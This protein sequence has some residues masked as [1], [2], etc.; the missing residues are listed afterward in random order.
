MGASLL[1]FD[2]LGHRYWLQGREVRSV[3]TILRM[4]GYIDFYN[5]IITTF[6][7]GQLSAFET[8]T[9][10]ERRQIQLEAARD[11]GKRVHLALHYLFDAD[12]D[13]DSVDGE[14]RGYLESAQ[15]YLALH[16]RK[17]YRVEM[18]V[19]S[20]KN[21]YAG[22]LD[23]LAQHLD[24]GLLSVD[25]FKTGDPGDVAAAEQTAG[26]L[27]AALEMA[28]VDAELAAVLRA[29][30]PVIRRRA[31]RLFRDGRPGRETVYSDPRDYSHFLNALAVANDLTIRRPVPLDWD[32]ER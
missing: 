3:T 13:D 11:R 27:G 23:L 2:P 21:W 32:D 24:D 14:V 16:V 30:G 1:T 25:D 22:T 26:Y 18:R 15:G 10:L 19:W 29:H 20:L 31:V 8:V 12:L 9:R 7:T 6:L 5:D 17:V 4:A 28:K